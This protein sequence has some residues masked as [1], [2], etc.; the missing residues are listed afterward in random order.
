MNPPIKTHI[1]A[2]C[3]ERAIRPVIGLLFFILQDNQSQVF[4]SNCFFL[5]SCGDI[6]NSLAAPLRDW[7]FIWG[8][9]LDSVDF[10]QGNSNT[11]CSEA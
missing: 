10:N 8:T 4:C 1:P 9:V 7:L 2:R 3:K 6:T 11:S 5:T